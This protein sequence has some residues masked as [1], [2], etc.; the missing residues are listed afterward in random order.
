MTNRSNR[1]RRV[2]I[3]PTSGYVGVAVDSV[4]LKALLA[5][6]LTRLVSGDFRFCP[7]P[8]CP[9]VYFSDDGQQ[10]FAEAELRERVYQ[11]HLKDETVLVCYCFQHT[12]GNIRSE[13]QLTG[14]STVTQSITR[15]IRAGQCACDL[16]NPQGSCCLGNV[17]DL[18]KRLLST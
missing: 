14:T 3:C 4:T 11:K 15:G 2:P 12:V 8:D 13:L 1:N 6:P 9:T 7:D 5:V 10:L 18:I 17:R 16:R